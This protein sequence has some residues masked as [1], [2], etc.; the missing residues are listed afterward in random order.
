M[1]IEE[2]RWEG[3]SGRGYTFLV[4]DIGIEFVA[5]PGF[6]IFAKRSEGSE[7]GWEALKIAY[8]DNLKSELFESEKN[9]CVIKN[10]ATHIHSHME[11][12]KD[13]IEQE[14]KDLVENHKSV[15]G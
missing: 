1:D 14:I 3:K 7:N 9:E 2:C 5:S 4:Y 13:R 12:D 15:C 8:T 6:Y 10:G 11:R